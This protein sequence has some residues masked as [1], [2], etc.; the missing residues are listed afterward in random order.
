MC[1][2]RWWKALAKGNV[3]ESEAREPLMEEDFYCRQKATFG[4]ERAAPR[5]IFFVVF[6]GIRWW[7]GVAKPIAGSSRTGRGYGDRMAG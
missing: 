1:G 4:T 2:I 6:G 5:T 3:G 7:K